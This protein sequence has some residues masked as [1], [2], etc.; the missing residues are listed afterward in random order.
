MTGVTPANCQSLL[1][2]W[3]SMPINWHSRQQSRQSTLIPTYN[4][5]LC[6]FTVEAQQ[7]NEKLP[8]DPHSV[9]NVTKTASR[10][11]LEI[12]GIQMVIRREDS[13]TEIISEN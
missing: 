1:N 7:P 13:P 2:M 4:H 9:G 10:I 3:Q 5:G 6:L 11:Y 8:R 12:I